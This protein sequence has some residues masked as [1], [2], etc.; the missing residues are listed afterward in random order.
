MSD[1]RIT[2]PGFYR[3]RDGQK[4]EIIRYRPESKWP[5]VGA[6]GKSWTVEGIWEPSG[7]RTEN[8]LVA[9]WLED[10]PTEL[11][12]V[13]PPP[14]PALFPTDS[15]E[16]KQYPVFTG[17]VKYFPRAIAAVS[18]VSWMGNEQ[19]HPGTPLHWDMSKSSD[20]EDAQMRHDMEHATG[21][22]T[23]DKGY[24]VLAQAAWRAMAKLERYL[25]S[26]ENQQKGADH[27][28]R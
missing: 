8:D 27:G 17:F 3:Q 9:V 20:E 12:C 4:A 19:H 10:L 26:L 28:T 5:C 21:K 1:F 2:G 22:V 25:L 14:S 24:L 16:R 18:H 23:D 6:D 7:I 15:A 13:A 11:K